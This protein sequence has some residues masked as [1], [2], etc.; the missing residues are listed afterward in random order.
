MTSMSSLL[1]EGASH[2]LDARSS[3]HAAIGSVGH[4]FPG[5]DGDL[6]ELFISTDDVLRRVG[7]LQSALDGATS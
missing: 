1:E 3:I 4:V 5:L 7:R 2:L 6:Q